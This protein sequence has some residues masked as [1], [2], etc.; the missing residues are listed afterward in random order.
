MDL[1]QQLAA[2]R[3]CL[4]VV[5]HILEGLQALMQD[6]RASL[7]TPADLADM[8]D[9]EELDPATEIR[10]VIDCVLEDWIGPAI[11]DVRAVIETEPAERS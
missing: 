11:R 5:A 4:A 10:A 7:P 6:T 2:A 9:I 3:R 1:T 8:E